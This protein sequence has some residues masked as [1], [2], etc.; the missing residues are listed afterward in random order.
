LTRV[1]VRLHADTLDRQL[2]R[3]AELTPCVPRL[4]ALPSLPG[5]VIGIVELVDRDAKPEN[6]AQP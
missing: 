1:F 2:D 4:H 5:Q 6:G 3:V